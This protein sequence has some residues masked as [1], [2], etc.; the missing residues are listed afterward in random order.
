[1]ITC[2]IV[3]DEPLA[4]QLLAAYAEKSP[5]LTVAGTFTNPIEALHFLADHPVDVLF[6]DV[7][8]PELTG[9]QLMK[10]ARGDHQVV[11]T[12]AYEKYAIEGYELNLTDY[13]LKPVSLD[14]FLRAVAK[15]KDRMTPA[16]TAS[17]T[18]PAPASAPSPESAE[19]SE[20]EDA[21]RDFLFVKSGHKT[22]RVDYAD[23]IR[24]ESMSNYVTLHTP[25]GKVMTLDKMTALMD[26]LPA[27]RFVRIHR[28][29]AVALDKIDFIERNRVV[30]GEDYL[31]ISD[32]YKEAFWAR[33]K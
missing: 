7:Q 13:L 9:L 31:P 19:G 4:G 33:I 6:L 28:S 3:D 18:S 10:I 5:D 11:L 17:P 14:R 20:K 32:G 27:A 1:M 2:I 12:T 30:I 25:A 8:M 23:I 24:L 15:V 21:G 26:A 29:H 16:N 22:V